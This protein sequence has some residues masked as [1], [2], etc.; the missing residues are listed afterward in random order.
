MRC[1]I[2]TAACLVMFASLA[3]GAPTVFFK[4]GTKEIGSSVWVD[5][6]KVYLNKANEVYEYGVEEVRMDE[7]LKFNKLDAYQAAMTLTPKNV[8]SHAR[9]PAVQRAPAKSVAPTEEE[10]EEEPFPSNVY[11]GSLPDG[12]AP[13][14]A[15]L[16]SDL[17]AVYK[18]YCQAAQSGDFKAIYPYMTKSHVELSVE[19]IAQVT[20]KR[21]LL[22]RKKNMQ[23]M[24]TKAIVPRGSALS[25]SGNGAALVVK[26]KR[27][28]SNGVWRDGI[29]TV[30]F[31]KEEGG[32]KVK[33]EIWGSVGA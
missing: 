10:R 23:S 13:G 19:A 22:L 3:F 28:E 31:E 32:W 17:A 8:P 25:P 7:T 26:G 21:E 9:N 1:L 5:N 16:Q 15:R 2:L 20:D 27:V 24:A 6:D 11:S 33:F 18:K 30:L 4:D 12:Y 29:G 14:A